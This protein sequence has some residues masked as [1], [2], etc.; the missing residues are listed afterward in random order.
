MLLEEREELE[1]TDTILER[2][3]LIENLSKQ[4]QASSFVNMYQ[5]QNEVSYK[6][7]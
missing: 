7:I 5:N 1:R 3:P 2:Q 6:G 4:F